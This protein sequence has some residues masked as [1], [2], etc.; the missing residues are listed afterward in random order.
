[1]RVRFEADEWYA[2]HLAVYET[3]PAQEIDLD[4]A[5]LVNDSA[6]TRAPAAS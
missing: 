2:P 1:M 5:I 3:A 6:V 4:F